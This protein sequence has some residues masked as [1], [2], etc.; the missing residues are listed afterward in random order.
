MFEALF[1][2][3]RELNILADEKKLGEDDAKETF[4]LLEKWDEVLGVLPLRMEEKIP[5][6]LTQ[7]LAQRE[8]A[9][10]V[11]NFVESD[12]MRDAIHARGYLI[13]DTPVGARLKKK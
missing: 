13:E 7:M 3:I 5:D 8:K 1:D 9:R 6:E 10:L 2:L 4:T 11:R 12:Q